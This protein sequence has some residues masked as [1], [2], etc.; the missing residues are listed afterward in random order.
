MDKALSTER[1]PTSDEVLRRVGRNLVIFQQIERGL[2]VLLTN[3]RYSSPTDEFGN[4][5]KNTTPNLEAETLG[6]LVR[7]HRENVLCDAGEELPE[8][9]SNATLQFAFR[10]QGQPEFIEKLTADFEAMKKERNELVHH[11]LPRWQPDNIDVLNEALEY[12]DEQ[13]ARA[14]PISDYLRSNLSSMI[15]A[16]NYIASP[17]FDQ[18]LDMLLLQATPL[19]AFF[20]EV[21]KKH[22]RDDGWTY[23]AQAGGLAGQTFPDEVKDLKD[24]YGV[25]TLKKLLIAAEIFEVRDEPTSGGSF[26]TIY[27]RRNDA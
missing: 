27:K 6:K 3:H 13:R 10:V 25:T 24:R 7:M 16:A 5:L 26:R 1:N 19:V 11:F 20:Q 12:L 8:Q 23:L 15:D 18:T 22:H 9:S 17:E 2:K 21:A 14:V 4:L